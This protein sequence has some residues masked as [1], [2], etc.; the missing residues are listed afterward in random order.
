MTQAL[1]DISAL[2]DI[3]ILD[4]H[5]HFWDFD[6]LFYPFLQDYPRH[7]FFL[8]DNRPIAKTFLPEDYLAGTGHHQVVGTVHVEAEAD[9][10]LQVEETQ[11]LTDLNARTGLPCA[12]VAHAWFDTPNAADI[13][14]AHAQ[15]PLVRAVRSK[16]IT[17]GSPD[18]DVR[19]LPRSMQDRKWLDGYRRLG[20]H[21]FGW[22]LRVPYWHLEE[23][24]R[25]AGDHP[26]IPVVLNHTGF[27]WLRTQ[28]GLE[29]WRKGMR[30]LAAIPHVW[31][32]LSCVCVPGEV[33]SYDAH[34]DVVREAI[35]IFGTNRCMFASNVPPDS[36][37]VPF[38]EMLDAYKA[39][40]VDFS[41]AECEA[42]FLGNAAKFYRVAG[43]DLLDG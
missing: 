21:G 27:P 23:A 28:E 36:L 16:P 19:G 39:M 15:Y 14:A 13:L 29:G 2:A 12:I 32:K 1:P 34:R 4:A 17:G 26:D 35:D 31:L 11:W 24:A 30:A 43:T 18:E 3:R 33:W 9:R 40:V 20:E 38:V 10:S 7:G 37:Q 25:V 22:D 41:R 8:G 6:A 42:M 5:H